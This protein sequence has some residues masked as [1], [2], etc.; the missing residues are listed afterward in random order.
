MALIHF[1]NSGDV[2]WDAGFDD[3]NIIWVDQQCQT[4]LR[5]GSHPKSLVH[6]CSLEAEGAEGRIPSQLL[7]RSADAASPHKCALPGLLRDIATFH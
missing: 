2:S 4:C 3:G 1:L 6:H 5:A 7:G